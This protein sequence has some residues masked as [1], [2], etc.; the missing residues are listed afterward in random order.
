MKRLLFLCTANYY[1]SRFSEQYFNHHAR[2]RG[3]AWQA[4]SKAITRHPQFE[5]VEGPMS[6]HSIQ[7]LADLGLKA[8]TSRFPARVEDDH[9]DHYHRVIA[10]SRDEHFPM[11][12]AHFPH[13]AQA[14]D[15][16]T[17]EDLHIYGPEQ[18]MPHLVSSLNG[19]LEELSLGS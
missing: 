7:Y 19:L 12:Q 18:A 16:F 4:D 8:D 5:G 14:I 13:R 6:P 1:R 10:A 2:L 15:Y 11:M 17:V 9:F 3:L